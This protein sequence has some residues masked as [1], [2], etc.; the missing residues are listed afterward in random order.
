[1]DE[2]FKLIIE[3]ERAYCS[4]QLTKLWTVRQIDNIFL[5]LHHKILKLYQFKLLVELVVLSIIKLITW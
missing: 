2:T 4:D 5:I 3:E 1:M